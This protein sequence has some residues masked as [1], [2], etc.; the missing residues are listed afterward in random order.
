MTHNSERVSN[1]VAHMTFKVQLAN[2]LAV[3]ALN[4]RAKRS[5]GRTDH[6]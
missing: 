1:P 2:R 6:P 3:S 5:A 4:S